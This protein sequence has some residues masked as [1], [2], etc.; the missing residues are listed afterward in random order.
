MGK[1][2]RNRQQIARQRIAAQQAA[3][4]AAAAR[5]RALMAGG[6]V[7]VVLVLVLVLVLVKINAK[8]AAAPK[9]G[10]AT[11]AAVITRDVTTIPASVF[12]AVGAGPAGAGKVDPL[13]PISGA[14]LTENGKPEVLFLGAE[15][16][17][18]CAAERWAM[19]AALS[20]FGTL[21]GLGLI[22]S[23][24]NDI[25][26]NTATL[27]FYKSSYVSQYLAFTPVE[28]QTVA[29]KQLQT[30][31]AAQRQ[32]LTKWDVPPYT[33]Q[34]G[35]I[36][37]IYFDGKYVLNTSQYLPT[38]LGTTGTEDPGHF[39]L[40][41]QQIA[42]DLRNPDSPVAQSVLGSAN[43][44]TAGLCTLT[45]GQPGSVCNSPAVKAIG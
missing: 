42:A 23:T 33:N 26:S 32:L 22:H 41:W 12:N 9:A 36:P 38:V 1:A 5:R 39:G 15:Y 35:S 25:Y 24:P 10:S 29:E 16:C 34:T 43:T 40:T 17:P 2:E 14:P 27:D 20:R 30:P 21:S 6:S 13:T 28:L 4:R 18:Y 37:F 44:I 11:M 45:G 19:A 31:T 8:P 3:A 7:V